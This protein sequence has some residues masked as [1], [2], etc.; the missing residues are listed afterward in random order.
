M[1]LEFEPLYPRYIAAWQRVGGDGNCGFRAVAV[2][3]D[4]RLEKYHL[5][6]RKELRNTLNGKDMLAKDCT[7]EEEEES[8]RVLA[9]YREAI[10]QNIDEELHQM[11]ICLSYNSIRRCQDKQQFHMIMPVTGEATAIFMLA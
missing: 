5:Q 2:C 7:L 10:F 8:A 3:T 9:N 1:A 11:Q 6:V 4:D